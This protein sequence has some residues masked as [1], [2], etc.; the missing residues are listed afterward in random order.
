[1]NPTFGFSPGMDDVVP[2]YL[3]DVLAGG[4]PEEFPDLGRLLRVHEDPSQWVSWTHWD[5]VQEVYGID[6]D[7]G[8][9]RIPW[10]NVGVQYGLRAVATGAITPEEFLDLNARVG[11]WN[12]PEEAVLES[13]ALASAIG[14]ETLGLLAAAIGMCE[15][16]EPD[17]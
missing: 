7:S 8:Y 1:M 10:D 4:Y 9:A 6:P 15:G 14:G 12:E 2:L 16:D 17:W 11:S 5:D 3:D 13:C